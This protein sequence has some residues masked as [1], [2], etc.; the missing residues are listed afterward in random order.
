M[1]KSD[2]KQNLKV[3]QDVWIAERIDYKVHHAK[4]IRECKNGYY[5]IKYDEMS[6]PVMLEEGSS[7]Y[8]TSEMS[9]YNFL[10]RIAKEI[11]DNS[12]LDH[13]DDLEDLRKIRE[14]KKYAMEL[15][16]YKIERTENE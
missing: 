12:L 9:A 5:L 6:N 13:Q 4:V 16:K 2:K 7:R 15:R 11:A 3:G 1:N 8:F 10:I 14:R